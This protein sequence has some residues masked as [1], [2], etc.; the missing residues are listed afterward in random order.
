[1]S[2]MALYETSAYGAEIVNR[3]D[4]TATLRRFFDPLDR[5]DS[6]CRYGVSRGTEQR[7]E[8]Y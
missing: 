6:A 5:A 3:S 1:M 7:S 2:L 8:R 4:R